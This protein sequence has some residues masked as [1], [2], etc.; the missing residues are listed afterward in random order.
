MNL[1]QD[2]SVLVSFIF[3]RPLLS[4]SICKEF[5]DVLVPRDDFLL[6]Y[7]KH[8]ADVWKMAP[9]TISQQSTCFIHTIIKRDN[10][11]NGMV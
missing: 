9:G 5:M 10:I 7:H 2:S 8:I 11:C 3:L 4:P 6:H 1:D